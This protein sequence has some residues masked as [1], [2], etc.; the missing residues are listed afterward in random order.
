MIVALD[1]KIYE[2]RRDKLKQIEALGQTAY[3]YRYETTHTIPPILEEYSSK[4]ALSLNRHA[5]TSASRDALCPFAC[6]GRRVSRIFSRVA[7]GCRSTSG[8]TTSARRVFSSTN[9]STSVTTSA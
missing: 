4:T 5:S 2:L 9:S 6:R 7:S 3:P 8:S 1:Q